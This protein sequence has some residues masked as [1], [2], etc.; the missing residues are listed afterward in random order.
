MFDLR[1]A[2]SVCVAHPHALP[3][4]NHGIA[5]GQMAALGRWRR[6][7]GR[8]WPGD[9][10]PTAQRANMA[11]AKVVASDPARVTVD[12]R[13]FARPLPRAAAPDE[14]ECRKACGEHRQRHWLRHG[15]T[16]GFDID[17]K[18]VG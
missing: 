13:A 4:V 8:V 10:L 5:G 9:S 18:A 3:F 17:L 14:P 6:L 15:L 1:L 16:G 11:T 12:A 7:G 2:R